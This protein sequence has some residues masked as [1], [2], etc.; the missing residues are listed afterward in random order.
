MAQ[1][2]GAAKANIKDIVRRKL[3]NIGAPHKFYISF[4]RKLDR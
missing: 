1:Q 4:D 3:R 2:V